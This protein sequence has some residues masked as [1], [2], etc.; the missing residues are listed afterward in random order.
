MAELIKAIFPR[1]GDQRRFLCKLQ[2][3]YDAGEDARH[4]YFI[5]TGPGRNAKTLLDDVISEVFE[6][7]GFTVRSIKDPI[8]WLRMAAPDI[9]LIHTEKVNSKI[10]R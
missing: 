7:K 10:M 9:S 1:T 6:E 2:E 5:F 8:D 3:I 4:C